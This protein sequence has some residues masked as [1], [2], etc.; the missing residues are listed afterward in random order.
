V[1]KNVLEVGPQL[2]ATIA[3]IIVFLGAAFV[4][5]FR[6]R[7]G[8]EAGRRGHRDEAEEG[9][10]QRVSPSGFIDSFAGRVEEAGGGLPYTGWIIMGVVLV[11]YFAYLFLF[12]NP[13]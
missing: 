12:W 1:P 2:F 3:G 7:T 11:C 9:I 8:A 10:E 6:Y 4:F 13:R 5:S